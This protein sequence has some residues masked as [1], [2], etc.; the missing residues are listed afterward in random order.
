MDGEQIIAL[1]RGGARSRQAAVGQIYERYSGEFARY[2]RWHGATPEK[3][4]DLVQETFVKLLRQIDSYRGDGP[5]EAWLWAVARN[6]LYTDFRGARPESSLDALEPE[7]ADAI[8]SG[9]ATSAPG[10]PAV[11]DCIARAL[12]RF[13]S[14]FP[15]YANILTRVVVDGWGYEELAAFRTS[16]N[17][18]ARE[19][20][21]QCRKRLEEFTRPCLDDPN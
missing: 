20:L 3:A 6:T 19:Y 14:R 10:D 21:S 5:F 8:I 17:G 18:A 11:A 13:T 15:D 4:E 1:M 16:S 7:A 9:A 12:A 2:F